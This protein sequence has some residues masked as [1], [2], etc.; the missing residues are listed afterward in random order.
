[1]NP[2]THHPASI[3]AD[4]TVP[5]QFE[6]LE[7]LFGARLTYP[8]FRTQ[9]IGLFAGVAAFL[10][11]V[12]IFSVLAYLVGQRTRELAVRRALGASA[13]NVIG[14]I[15]APGLRLVAA[16][17]VLGLAGA[18]ASARLLSGLLY[19]ITPWD[20]RAYVGTIAVLGGVALFAI[21][22]PGIRAATIPPVTVL[23]QE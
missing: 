23:Q 19:E 22:V 14:L 5:I 16:G 11:A 4:P 17:L 21:L 6:T 7:E 15:M 12:G 18:A 20:V 10:A 13:A 2:T 8:R 3:E 1:M 9:V